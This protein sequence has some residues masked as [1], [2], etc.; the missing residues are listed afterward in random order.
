MG[1]CQ[2]SLN[3]FLVKLYKEFVFVLLML[4]DYVKRKD[5]LVFDKDDFYLIFEFFESIFKLFIKVCDLMING[6]Y[7]DN[8]VFVFFML[9]DMWFLD[10]SI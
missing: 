8:K 4:D 6:V 9:E 2:V 7:W 5:G 10:F 3:D 1:I